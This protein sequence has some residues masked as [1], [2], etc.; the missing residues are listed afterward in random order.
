MNAQSLSFGSLRRFLVTFTPMLLLEIA[1]V[2][3]YT[4]C[5]IMIGY[6]GDPQAVASY[7][8]YNFFLNI[9]ISPFMGSIVEVGS[10]FFAKKFGEKD[11][12]GLIAYFWKTCLLTVPFLT[13]FAVVAFHSASILEGIGI[14]SQ[15][16]KRTGRLINWAI[17]TY[18]FSYLTS[19]VQSYMLS[20]NI[21]NEF[22]VQSALSF[23]LMILTAKIFIL[24]LEMNEVGIIPTFI[25][26]D[27]F[28]AIYTAVIAIRSLDRRAIGLCDWEAVKGDFVFF[29]KKAM[30]SAIGIFV[31]FLTFEFNTFLVTQLYNVD[32]LAIYV[33]WTSLS[34]V[35]YYMVGAATVA[36]RTNAG[37]LI[38]AGYH[39]RAK[40][41]TIAYFIYTAV[42]MTLV[43][44]IVAFFA[45][46]IA[47]LFLDAPELAPQLTTAV[48]VTALLLFFT[49]GFYPTIAVLRLL[50]L[51]VYFMK[52]TVI[53]YF[54]L[55]GVL[56]SLL[57]FGFGLGAV[58]VVIGHEVSA[59]LMVL[60]FFHKI[61]LK[62]DWSSVVEVKE[63]ILQSIELRSRSHF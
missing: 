9:V 51:D 31:D 15:V 52:M 16:A 42:T 1:N 58:G 32:Q 36:I 10:V 59:T 63:H 8:L 47:R 12:A 26:Q 34:L 28:A 2:T 13:G 25:V 5:S 19:I 21:Q 49:T 54:L 61:F 18:P 3:P 4:A 29:A 6:M 20:Q 7:G 11:W 41:E 60:L 35:P 14:E 24:D 27:V 48:Y 43:S 45:P 37:Q 38:G 39:R 57:C 30:I 40:R 17:I 53:V 22:N 44:V 33:A 50:N 56:S 23:P 55:N 46:E 62:F